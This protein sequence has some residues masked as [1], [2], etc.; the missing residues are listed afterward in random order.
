MVEA[1]KLSGVLLFAAFV[2][3]HHPQSYRIREILNSEELGPLRHISSGM[4]FNLQDKTD[5]R[6]IKE[7]G[8]GSI[9]DGGVYPITFSRFIAG[10]DPISVHAIMNI[11]EESGVDLRTVL[12]LEYPNEVTATL[13]SAFDSG[14]SQHARVECSNGYLDIPSP[15]HKSTPRFGPK[16][17]TRV[18]LLS[19]RRLHRSK[20]SF[21]GNK[22]PPSQPIPP[23]APSKLSN[24]PSNLLG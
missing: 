9:Y 23:S 5:I 10:A 11:D 7:L 3:L 8:G 13:Y 16:K 18:F 14:G 1:C 24:P 21:E 12:I 2:F 19:S 17:S 15:F 20:N 22:S 6:M 4:T